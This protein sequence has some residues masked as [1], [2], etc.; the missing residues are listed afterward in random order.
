MLLPN[1]KKNLEI[2]NNFICKSHP[3][4]LMEKLPYQAPTDGG[5]TYKYINNL[6][7]YRLYTV[8]LIAR[9]QQ[10]ENILLLTNLYRCDYGGEK[11][12]KG[13]NFLCRFHN[14]KK[15]H[16]K[17]VMDNE[18]CLGTVPIRSFKLSPNTLIQLG[19]HLLLLL[20]FFI[21]RSSWVI[22]VQPLIHRL[23]SSNPRPPPGWWWCW[24]QRQFSCC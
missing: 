9:L 17:L 19:F 11:F 10:R 7:Q 16:R 3:L 5:C 22:T 21:R 8:F 12:R 6:P 2:I 14:S 13:D 15:H 18:N 1:T 20:T 24:W 4:N 23:L